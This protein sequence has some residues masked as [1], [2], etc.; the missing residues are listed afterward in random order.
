MAKINKPFVI[1]VSVPF[2]VLFLDKMI[3]LPQFWESAQKVIFF[4]A[5]TVLIIF[6]FLWI[7]DIFV[8]YLNKKIESEIKPLKLENE[9]QYALIFSILKYFKDTASPGNW[10]LLTKKVKNR[11]ENSSDGN[12]KI[13]IEII[14]RF[15]DEMRKVDLY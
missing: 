6:S 8:E 10:D 14:C 13:A 4:C 3:D 9:M 2:V 7:W 12:E 15:E 1:T 11:I 5:L